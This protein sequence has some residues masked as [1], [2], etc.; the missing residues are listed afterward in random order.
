MGNFVLIYLAGVLVA[1]V[2]LFM[3]HDH[4]EVL[5]AL[6]QAL[7]WPWHLALWVY[8]RVRR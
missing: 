3:R 1:S 6:W 8:E 7:R 2:V 4:Y 5:D